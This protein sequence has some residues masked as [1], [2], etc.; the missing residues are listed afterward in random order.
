M[1]G[2]KINKV[3]LYAEINGYIYSNLHIYMHVCTKLEAGNDVVNSAHVQQY[4]DVQ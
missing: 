1:N 3:N 2:Y 4:I